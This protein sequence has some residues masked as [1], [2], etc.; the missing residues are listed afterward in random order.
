VRR[1]PKYLLILTLALAGCDRSPDK[2]PVLEQNESLAPAGL[3]IVTLAPHL[4][5]L[6]FAIGAGDLLVGVTAYT[7]YPPAAAVLP[8][9]GDAFAVDL[10]ELGIL[11]PDLLLA[12]ESGT[13]AHV[14]DELR[15]RGYR[16]E[17]IETRG[18]DDIAAALGRIGSLTGHEKQ[19]ANAAAVFSAGIGALAERYRKASP[20]SVF[21]QVSSRPLY[22]VNGDHYVSDLI[23]ICG[24][25]NIF[26]D[27]SSLAPL[28]DVEAVLSRNPEAM[29]ASDDNLDDAFTV[30]QRW[31]ELA[32]ARYGNFFFLPAD[33]IGRATP[34]LLQAGET[35]CAALDSARRNRINPRTDSDPRL[36]RIRTPHVPGAA[37]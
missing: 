1:A 12:W 32:A 15:R 17:T 33:E 30:W 27:L 13:A 24:G 25:R 6:V 19:A 37:Q 28:V 26:D 29:L 23:E 16:I 14:I 2:G 9:V 5:E 34:R 22:T 36:S 10:E 20:I 3:R 7:D 18:I 21:Y 4:A 31:P 35:L 8:Q 11:G